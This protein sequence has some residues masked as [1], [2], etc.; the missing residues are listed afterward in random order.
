MELDELL[1]KGAAVVRRDEKL[2]RL[3]IEYFNGAFSFTPSCAGC[4]FNK[5]FSRLK[6][7]AKHKNPTINIPNFSPMGQKYKIKNRHRNDILSYSEDGRTYRMYGYR[8]TDDFIDKYLAN[9]GAELRAKRE[10]KF[11]FD[12]DLSSLSRKQLDV[13]AEEAG[14]DPKSFKNKGEVIQA[15]DGQ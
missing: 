3:Y 2:M 11:D 4:T 8:A 15:L 10:K 14:L 1:S 13:L 12:K 7:W 9:A 5:D 6:K